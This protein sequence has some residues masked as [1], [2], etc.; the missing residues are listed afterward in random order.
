MAEPVLPPHPEACQDWRADVAGWA[1]AHLDPAREAALLAHLEGCAACRSEA[2]SLVAVAGAL[3][4][5]EPPELREP[6]PVVVD[7]AAPPVQLGDRISAAIGAERRARRRA[8]AGLAALAGAVA[9]LLVAVAVSTM[10][11]GGAPAALE[12]DA[13]AFTDVP[14]GATASAVVAR[15]GTGTLVELTATGLDPTTTYALWLTPPDGGWE[16]RVPAGTFRPDADGQVDVRLPCA[17]AVDDVDRI[18]ATTPTGDIAL[19]T[20]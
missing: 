7:D 18:W 17:L 11:G 16:A 8:R 12:G 1:I 13:V 10:A 2:D 4:A 6:L 14:S 9:A 3:L 20:Q 15:D 19:D 5:A